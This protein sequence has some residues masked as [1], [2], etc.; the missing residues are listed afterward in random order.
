MVARSTIAGFTNR[1]HGRFVYLALENDI[2]LLG[3][4]MGD[5]LT[6][7]KWWNFQSFRFVAMPLVNR[8]SGEESDGDADSREIAG[9]SRVQVQR[10]PVSRRGTIQEGSAAVQTGRCSHSSHKNI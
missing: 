10:K 8:L 5:I 7:G 9:V 3:F 2:H 1:T 6:A 4:A